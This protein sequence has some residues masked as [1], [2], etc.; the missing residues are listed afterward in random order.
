MVFRC[1]RDSW[2]R[3]FATRVVSCREAELRPESG[4]EPMRGFQVVLEDT[5]L[6]PEGG[7]QVGP[8]PGEERGGTTGPGQR[9]SV[10]AA[11]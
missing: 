4:G 3:Q 7:G 9:L 5:I 10:S 1:Q 8:G 6:F 11:R 2:A